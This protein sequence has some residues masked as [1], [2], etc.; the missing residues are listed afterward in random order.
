MPTLTYLGTDVLRL[1]FIRATSLGHEVLH[2]W[3]GNGVYVDYARGNWAEGLTTFMADYAYRE[4]E[5]AAAAREMRQAWLRDFAA[6][7]PGEDMPL[8]AFTSRTH[9][10]SQIVGYNKAAFLF[11]MLR[12]RLGAARFDAGLRQFWAS[13]QFRRAGWADLQR[14]FEAASGE[15]LDAF[16]AQWL[17]RRGA[18]Q[19]RVESA[20][21]ERIGSQQRLHVT[22]VQAGQP[23]ALSVPLALETD[24]GMQTHTVQVSQARATVVIDSAATVRSVHLDPDLRVLRRLD[25]AE[26]PPI[27]RQVILDPATRVQLALEADQREAGLALA[28]ALLDHA[29]VVGEAEADAPRLLIG[30]H[31]A[32]DRALA[33]AGLPARPASLAGRGSA[34]VWTSTSGSGR[35][36]AVISARDVAA[37]QAL[38]RPLP[39]YGRQSWL[40]FDGARAIDRGVWLGEA[41]AVP[42]TLR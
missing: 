40:V 15:A 9:G 33:A 32:V 17:E 22:V 20:Q 26:L 4:R 8:A 30:T 35:A 21:A 23:Y 6:I 14:A 5:S 34:Q 39:H 3:W 31:E 36:L 10:T 7:P 25:A 29:P 38:A 2:N 28:R 42:V 12:D 41:A 13:Q 24:A 16:F 27:L 18:P 11:L 37:L 1:P 19:L